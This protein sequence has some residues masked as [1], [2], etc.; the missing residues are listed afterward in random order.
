MSA[1]DFATPSLRDVTLQ[2][3]LSAGDA[4]YAEQ[5]VP[6]L[7]RAHPGVA[8][9]LAVV[10]CCRPQ[11]TRIFDPERRVPESGFHERLTRIRD[12]A[13]GFQKQGL[14]DD[15]VWLETGSPL[16]Q[17][18]ATRF[19]RPWMIETHDYGGCAFM[20][21]WA[22]LDVPATRFVLHY[23][24][25][26][27]LY[28]EADFDWAAEALRHWSM[29]PQVVAATPRIS[30]PG[31]ARTPTE[32]A[33]SLHE[34]R[35]A[36]RVPAGWLNDWFS[37]RC[38]LM[39]RERLAPNLPLVAGWRT[40]AFWFRRMIDRGYPVGPEILLHQV[41]GPRGLRRLNLADERAWL[42]H[43]NSKPANFLAM[44]PEILAAVHSGRIPSVQRGHSDFD[45]A[46]WKKFLATPE[47]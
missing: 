21:Y 19:V 26:M 37:T 41:L 9:R 10:D 5:T 12:L 3:N 24:A 18:F 16:F 30:P 4:S 15:V 7:V 14:F 20:G 46:A 31:F 25:D 39:D 43:P 2:I 13:A 45:L 8:R 36:E 22:A 1:T 17:R 32:D 28:Q 40:L 44:L 23:D 6:C 34:G 38:L 29:L 11:R 42:L 27:C 35:P 47:T 33:P